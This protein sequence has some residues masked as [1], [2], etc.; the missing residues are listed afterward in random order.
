MLEIYAPVNVFGFLQPMDL[1]VSL[2]H[3]KF[4]AEAKIT[5]RS[6]HLNRIFK[7]GVETHLS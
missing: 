3:I 2:C 5:G 4:N 7:P 6:I 1:P